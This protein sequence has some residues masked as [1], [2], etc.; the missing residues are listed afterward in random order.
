LRFEN[1]ADKFDKNATTVTL[2]VWKFAN[3]LYEQINGEKP[4]ALKVQETYLGGINI[5]PPQNKGGG[6]LIQA[7]KV[8]AKMGP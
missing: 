4:F 3:D 7:G 6:R 8:E 2:D 1:L 5:P